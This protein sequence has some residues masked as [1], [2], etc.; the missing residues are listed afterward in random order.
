MRRSLVF[1]V[2]ISGALWSARAAWAQSPFPGGA[3]PNT[4]APAAPPPTSDVVRSRQR[5]PEPRQEALRFT[6]SP[7]WGYRTFR[8]KESSS[9]DKLYAAPGIFAAA[10]RL[11]VYPLA[12]IT[13][14]PEV[15]RDFGLTVGYSRAFFLESRDIDTDTDVGTQWYQFNFGV[16]YRILGGN[17]PLSL[18]FTAAIQRWVYDFDATPTN[19]LVAIGRYTLLPVGVDARYAW[20]AFSIFGDG[21]F[22]WPITVSQ[23]G[24][25]AA[26]GAK[27]GFNVGL[28]AA[29]GLS[30]FFE[31]ELRGV[32]TLVTFALPTVAGRSDERG[33]VTDAYL[34]FSAGATF[35]Y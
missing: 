10:A 14:A 8:V 28:G 24:D 21:R 29:Y 27:L 15:G 5:E 13:P 32:Y 4:S 20:G 23:L 2:L 12:F 17:D 1:G 3:T 9:T 35:R 33:A 34:V 25:R 26:T 18:G 11:E 22:L 31:V 30:R 16:R 6:L 7:E 19:R